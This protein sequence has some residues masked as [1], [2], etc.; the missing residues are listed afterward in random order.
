[1][2]ITIKLPI[3]TNKVCLQSAGYQ[4]GNANRQQRQFYDLT[5]LYTLSSVQR[6]NKAL[7]DW[8]FD[9]FT[10]LYNFRQQNQI[11]V[12]KLVSA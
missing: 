12:F 8:K 3:A 4:F 10:V 9:H 11:N 7:N 2:R 1:M 5:I 6:E